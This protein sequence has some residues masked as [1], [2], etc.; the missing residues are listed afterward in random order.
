MGL[1]IY[2]T[3]AGIVSSIG[4]GIENTLDSLLSA[5]SGIH[6]MKY[7]TSCHNEFPVGEVDMTNDEMIVKLG[8]KKTS[9]LSRTSLL[10]IMALKEALDNAQITSEDISKIPL[11][12]STTVGG[13]DL[14]ELKH[15]EEKDCDKEGALIATQ[16]CATCTELIADSFGDF[17]S[18]TTISTACS[19]AMNAI[20][21]G[22]NMIC[23]GM[24]DIVVVGGCEALSLY[25]LN[26][27]NSLMILDHEHCKPF[28]KE[29]H[30]LNLGEGAAYLVI[31][32]EK[33]ML[34]RKVKPIC[35]INGYG[36]ACDAFH[37][38]AISEEGTGPLM[39]M[40]EALKMA[41][42]SPN[43]IQYINAH[44]TGTNNND[45]SEWR[46]I[47]KVFCDKIPYISSTKSFTG[48]TTSASGSIETVISM[49]SIVHNFLPLNLN[50]TNKMDMG[51]IPV[52][53]MCPNEKISNVM[54]N[55]FGFGGNDSSL[56]LSRCSD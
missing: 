8:I 29:R 53:D 55:S 54:V 9:Y 26:G 38:T 21:L 16:N 6:K 7:L 12:S 22:V 47:E 41:K 36:N 15:S 17:A 2:I 51:F 24:E 13:I 19:S 14:R 30:G 44:G 31:E 50:W 1:N 56:I 35:V 37:Q 5:K 23:S 39:A 27:F 18:L 32:S 45:I 42:M 25:H 11:I 43:E 46:A 3:G 4:V 34:S 52:T 48:H 40:T 20:I 33:S 10:G 49:L 28:D